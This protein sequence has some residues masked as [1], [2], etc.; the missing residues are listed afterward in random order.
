M[1]QEMPE[2]HDDQHPHVPTQAELYDSLRRIGELE[3]Q[4]KSIQD[5]IDQ[6]TDQLRE[7]VKNLD[8]GSLLAKMLNSALSDTAAQPATSRRATKAA[9]KKKARTRR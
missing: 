2:Q 5:E 1:N 8:R 7:A 4:K 6:R 9:A 3:D